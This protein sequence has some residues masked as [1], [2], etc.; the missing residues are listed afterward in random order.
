MHNVYICPQAASGMPDHCQVVHITPL[1]RELIMALS[2]LPRLY[3]EQGADGRM[4][5]VFLDQLKATPEVPLHLP[6]PKASGCRP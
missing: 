1:L 3:D 5:D 4:V 6:Q 2:K